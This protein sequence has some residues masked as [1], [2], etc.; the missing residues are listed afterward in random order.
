MAEPVRI[1]VSQVGDELVAGVCS[2]QVGLAELRAGGRFDRTSSEVLDFVG[3]RYSDF[4]QALSDGVVYQV[5]LPI[6]R[7]RLEALLRTSI[8]NRVF[9]RLIFEL[10][11]ARG[12]A[13]ENWT[14]QAQPAG[15][16]LSATDGS[17]EVA[18][19][20]PAWWHVDDPED[21]VR[22]ANDLAARTELPPR[23]GLTGLGSL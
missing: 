14:L 16:L 13:L 5:S 20:D 15:L 18:H 8:R 22:I 21:A 4:R 23:W 9:G 11:V 7:E 19:V 3:A 1:V 6:E 10:C 17:F 2:D 12:V